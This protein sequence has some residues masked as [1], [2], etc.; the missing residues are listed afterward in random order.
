MTQYFNFRSECIY[1][2]DQDVYDA[3][4][5]SFDALPLSCLLNNKFLALHG[6]ISPELKKLKHLNE[7]DRFGE[8]PKEGMFCD[9]LWSDPVDNDKGTCKDLFEYNETRGCSYFFGKEAVNN[10]NKKNNLYTIIRAH[11]VQAEGY[12][13]HKWGSDNFPM[14]LTLF[15]APNYVQQYNNKGAVVIF[16]DNTLQIQQFHYSIQPYVLPDLMDVFT[17]S[18][19]FVMEK[20]TE[21][22]LYLAQSSGEDPIEER[23]LQ[24]DRFYEGMKPDF[25]KKFQETLNLLSKTGNNQITPGPGPKKPAPPVEDMGEGKT[26]VNVMKNK[27]NAIS[28]MMKM[29]RILR[30]NNEAII[31]VKNK[32]NNQLPMGILLEGT[33]AFA[34][35]TKAKVDDTKNESRPKYK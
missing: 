16:E 33:E 23:E 24:D 1:K 8:P 7:V 4:I 34:A 2:Y 17:W 29:Q 28:K 20:V 21:I 18:I 32:N 26:R 30:E 10:F 31:K 22:L 14:V 15:S 12:K 27:V 19:P 13:M 5:A 35:F 6:G 11:E 25:K 9:I 3:F